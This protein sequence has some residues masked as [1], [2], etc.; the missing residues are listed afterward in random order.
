MKLTFILGVLMVETPIIATFVLMWKDSGLKVAL[1]RFGI[2]IALGTW[3]CC[4]G[5]ELILSEC[6]I[7]VS[8][9]TVCNN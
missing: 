8:D 6:L 5:I 1:S 3:V 2:M 4:F 9:D 7:V